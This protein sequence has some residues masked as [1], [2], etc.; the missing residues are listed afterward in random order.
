MWTTK[1]LCHTEKCATEAAHEKRTTP[2][3]ATQP[4]A[5]EEY[6]EEGVHVFTKVKS[7]YSS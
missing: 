2:I 6:T 5:Y 3:A 7:M 4:F 1:D